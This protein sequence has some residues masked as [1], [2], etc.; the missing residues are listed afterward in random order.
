MTSNSILKD[1]ALELG[2][3]NK[4]FIGIIINRY[5]GNTYERVIV[6]RNWASYDNIFH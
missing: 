1:M 6:V 4:K 3:E 2:V 5:A